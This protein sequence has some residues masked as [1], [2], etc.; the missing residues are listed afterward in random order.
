[1][2]ALRTSDRRDIDDGRTPGPD[3]GARRPAAV[4]VAWLAAALLGLVAAFQAALVLGAPW[5][6]VTQG[7]GS[8]G[9][10]PT[11]GRIVAAVSCLVLMVMA[12]AVL[13]RVNR[14]PLRQRS[15]R[16]RTVLAWFTTVYA[17]LGVVLNLITQSTAERALWAPVSI[18]LLGLIGFVMVTSHHQGIA[19]A[20]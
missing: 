17:G 3:L 18:L 16:V 1:M 13:G 11:S 12:G 7:G 15:A 14:G 10:L 19:R 5:G 6:E 20:D 9:T 8:S 2:S 4:R